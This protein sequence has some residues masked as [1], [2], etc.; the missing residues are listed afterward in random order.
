[1]LLC[2]WLVLPCCRAVCL[3][4]Q[5]LQSVFRAHKARNSPR[6]RRVVAMRMSR[7]RADKLT[8]ALAAA[9]DDSSPARRVL[10]NDEAIVSDA[11]TPGPRSPGSYPLAAGTGSGAGAAASGRS[12]GNG[13][14]AG[15]GFSEPK[16]SGRGGGD[17]GDDDDGEGNVVAV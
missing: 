8:S 1:M 12:D 17:A 4:A 2:V 3:Q 9:D 14:G 11:G 10:F 13:S 15:V 6:L 7:H 16:P 5:M